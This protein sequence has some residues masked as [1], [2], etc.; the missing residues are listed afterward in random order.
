MRRKSSLLEPA[1]EQPNLNE[2]RDDYLRAARFLVSKG[3]WDAARDSFLNIIQRFGED[4]AILVELGNVYSNLGDHAAAAR[5][6]LRAEELGAPD[7]VILAYARML[8]K[9]GQK[10]EAIVY[11]RSKLESIVDLPLKLAVLDELTFHDGDNSN[12]LALKAQVLEEMGAVSLAAMAQLDLCEKLMLQ[13]RMDEAREACHKAIQL[14]PTNRDGQ[15][16]MRLLEEQ[17]KPLGSALLDEAKLLRDRGDFEGAVQAYASAIRAGN[18]SPDVHYALALVL[19]ELGRWIEATIHLQKA[20]EDPSLFTSVQFYLGRCYQRLGDIY[21]AA[22]RYLS[23]FEAVEPAKLSA[24]DLTE[25]WELAE[26]A[27]RTLVTVGRAREAVG[28][29][30][31]FQAVVRP[32]SRGLVLIERAMRLMDEILSPIAGPLQTGV[33]FWPAASMAPP[34]NLVPS[35]EAPWPDLV[36]HL[37]GNPAP[38]DGRTEVGRG[39]PVADAVE[40]ERSDQADTASGA[41]LRSMETGVTPQPS[42]ALGEALEADASPVEVS[43]ELEGQSV[44]DRQGSGENQV[45]AKLSQ[46]SQDQIAPNPMG[47]LEW[48]PHKDETS[49]M[50]EVGSTR[51]AGTAENPSAPGEIAKGQSDSAEEGADSTE[52]HAASQSEPLRGTGADSV[53][54][55]Q[56][57]TTR[58][59]EAVAINERGIA[60]EPNPEIHAVYGVPAEA[61]STLDESPDVVSQPSSN[62]VPNFQ[63]LA[64]SD[65]PQAE[66]GTGDG[67]RPGAP[68]EPGSAVAAAGLD[69]ALSGEEAGSSEGSSPEPPEGPAL[70]LEP[71][72]ATLE[73]SA[74]SEEGRPL[75]DEQKPGP[76]PEGIGQAQVDS[77]AN[78]AGDIVIPSQVEPGPRQGE[79]TGDFAAAAGMPASSEVLYGH[80]EIA[81][82]GDNT[83][84]EGGGPDREPGRP[85]GNLGSE[86]LPAVAPGELL[87]GTEE[88]PLRSTDPQDE[89]VQGDREIMAQRSIDPMG[90]SLEGEMELATKAEESPSNRASLDAPCFSAGMERY[91]G[92]DRPWMLIDEAHWLD[93][94]KLVD[95]LV[96]TCV[97]WA[98]LGFRKNFLATWHLLEA[99]WKAGGDP[100]PL[101]HVLARLVS[102]PELPVLSDVDC[103]GPVRATAKEYGLDE[104]LAVATVGLAAA[105]MDVANALELTDSGSNGSQLYTWMQVGVGLAS[106][107]P[108][109]VL[110]SEL[111]SARAADL[112]LLEATLATGT[113]P[114]EP[115]RAAIESCLMLLWV[116]KRARTMGWLG[117][118]LRRLGDQAKAKRAFEL[119]NQLAH[120]NTEL[121]RALAQMDLGE[122]LPTELLEKHKDE[123]PGWMLNSDEESGKMIA[124][125]AEQLASLLSVVART[126]PRLST[127]LAP[128]RRAV[129]L[130]DWSL[131]VRHLVDLAQRLP[132]VAVFRKMAA[133]AMIRAGMYDEA[134]RV[135]V[136]LAESLKED[137]PEEAKRELLLAAALAGSLGQRARQMLLI[138]GANKM[139]T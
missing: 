87:K 127:I 109:S 75:W 57:G 102:M 138:E 44:P 33:P 115:L 16:L 20:A 12:M 17:T 27:A 23:A 133:L 59:E 70:R 130:N 68:W 118:L 123:L 47:T 7:E 6:Y 55:P 34:G 1:P 124:S 35:F 110:L 99:L 139:A 137:K 46:A 41:K 100:R 126:S 83:S 15:Q 19:M 3:R 71:A 62:E 131:T 108:E 67:E 106:G 48:D 98:Y 80:W 37:P 31:Q 77:E 97:G 72:M 28:V 66:I 14:D 107:V 121:W 73:V 91:G 93:G 78:F 132:K 36:S 5:S 116:S 40:A 84:A 61:K 90:S 4:A 42:A 56:M 39:Q 82:S 69:M 54:G 58:A 94:S 45:D 96:A 117:L 50:L 88:A 104:D 114:V 63:A 30:R 65:T 64:T 29:L 8:F 119:A 95:R 13:G 2:V 122:A 101:V 52:L 10:D 111:A 32:Y 85:S 136:E 89:P 21:A 53:G 60:E 120:G 49:S 51:V 24:S 134:I 125:Q 129:E 38:V 25:Y 113:Y 9:M 128:V 135:L 79:G 43:G 22:D 26:A 76:Q 86:T 112:V 81:N 105:G 11:L 103:L 74:P 92:W 18:S